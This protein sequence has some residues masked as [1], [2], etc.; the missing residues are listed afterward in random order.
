MRDVT[1]LVFA[2]AVVQGLGFALG[3]IAMHWAWAWIAV[4]P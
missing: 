3:W 1:L 4:N 2:N